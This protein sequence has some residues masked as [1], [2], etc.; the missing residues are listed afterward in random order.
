MA[1][2]ENEVLPISVIAAAPP[3]VLDEF[4]KQS[5]VELIQTNPKGWS[6]EIADVKKSIQNYLQYN[7]SLRRRL[8]PLI[9]IL[10]I[11]S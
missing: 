7:H 8:I 1:T 5:F 9:Q 2:K 6:E 3:E 11:I 4:R 10:M